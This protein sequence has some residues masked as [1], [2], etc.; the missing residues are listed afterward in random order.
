MLNKQIFDGVTK[1]VTHP[2]QAHRDDYVSVALALALIPHALVER[3]EVEVDDPELEDRS[4]LFLDV[5]KRHEPELN[6][7]DH[8]QFTREHA[9]VCAL[10][11]LLEHLGILAVA[12]EAW[13]WLTFTEVADSKGPKVASEFVNPTMTAE[14]LHTVSSPI[15]AYLLRLF[16]EQKTL[17]PGDVLHTD[18]WS[19][20]TD[21]LEYVER[22]E[23]RL[24]ELRR[25]SYLRKKPHWKFVAVDVSRI[26]KFDSPLLGLEYYCKELQKEW[27]GTAVAVTVTQDDRGEGLCLFRRDDYP[28]IDFASLKAHP[29]VSFAHPGGFVAKLKP[30]AD[31]EELIELSMVE[32]AKV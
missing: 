1:I 17:I 18:L 13:S 28:G 16:K 29:D 30:G 32:S 15:E 20:G 4:V 24:V 27:N 9:P 22:F 3:R 12:R 7:F 21:M 2:G 5:G 10:T 8:H 26:S 23:Q 19:M 11:L 6:N 31:W 14:Q 25:I